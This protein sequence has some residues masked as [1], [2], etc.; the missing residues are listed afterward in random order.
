MVHLGDVGEVQA[1]FSPFRY[2]VNLN[3]RDVHCLSQTCN[4][5]GSHFWAHQMELLGDVGQVEAHFVSF[6]YS[7]NLD[8]S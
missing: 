4:R 7:V 1:R 2:S 8:T 3:A 6:G 5:F